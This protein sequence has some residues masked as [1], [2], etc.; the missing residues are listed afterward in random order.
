MASASSTSAKFLF[1]DSKVRLADRVQIN[2][3]NISSLARQITRGSKSNE[4]L[5]YS[6]RNFAAQEHIID[7][8]EKN[9]KKLLLLSAHL[10][11]QQESIKNSVYLVREI[12]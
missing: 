2:V 7:N 8:S 1:V 3:N 11:Y 5:M 12:Q 4:I 10:S 6:A 9:L